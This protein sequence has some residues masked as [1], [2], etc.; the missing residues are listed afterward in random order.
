MKSIYS[1]LSLVVLVLAGSFNPIQA[2]SADR[3]GQ[4]HALEQLYERQPGEMAN[5]AAA[6]AAVE[7]YL[8][9]NAGQLRVQDDIIYIP[10]VIHVV[11]KAG[12]QNISDAQVLSQIDILNEDYSMT[13]LDRA[14]L[15]SDFNSLAVN[16]GIQFCLAETDLGGAPTTVIIRKQ[17][18]KNSFNATDTAGWDGVKSSAF[19][20]SDP[21]PK[22]QYLNIWVCNLDPTSGVLGYAYPPGVSASQDGVVINYRYFGNQGVII[23]PY[24]LGRT[25]THEVGHWLGLRHIWG[26]GGCGVDDGIDD[27]PSS[28]GPNF[29]CPSSLV[30]TCGSLDLWENYMDYTDD[31]CMVMYTAGQADRMKAVLNTTRSTIPISPKCYFNT[32]V[33]ESLGALVQEIRLFPNP[34]VQGDLQV[35]LSSP[36]TSEVLLRVV[37]ATGRTV[38]TQREGAGFQAGTLRLPDLPNGFYVLQIS[39]DTVDRANRFLLAR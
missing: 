3:C 17:S 15:R 33:E 12:V 37:D 23:P 32:G 22:T 34:L 1:P 6:E 5:V 35:V 30:T 13:N 19:G 38:L 4:M 9:M 36:T 18:G 39:G 2:Q 8:R 14:N 27:T 7:E 16:S 11:Y 20:G 28:S 26:D 21:W 31:R 25:T 10:T 29:G 24:N